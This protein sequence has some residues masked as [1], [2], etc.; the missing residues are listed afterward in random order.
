M[1]KRSPSLSTGAL[2]DRKLSTLAVFCEA[3]DGAERRGESVAAS[4]TFSTDSGHHVAAFL[5]SFC[6]LLYMSNIFWDI[7]IRL[8]QP[9]SQH[10]IVSGSLRLYLRRIVSV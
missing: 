6:H 5:P 7:L 1:L 2:T 9:Q 10:L 4:P 8:L 3:P